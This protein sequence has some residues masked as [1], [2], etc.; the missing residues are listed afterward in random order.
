MLQFDDTPLGQAV[1]QAGRHGRPHVRLADPVIADLRV[2][3]AFRAG[4]T[5]GFAESVAAAF[6]LALERGPDGSLWLR[7][8]PPG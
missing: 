1:E 2:T 5:M 4:D 8:R 7:P 3:G 6:D